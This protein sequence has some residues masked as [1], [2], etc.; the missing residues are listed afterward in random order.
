M[1]WV[2]DRVRS[3]ALAVWRTYR[4]GLFVVAVGI[5]LTVLTPAFLVQGNLF[6]V[7]TNA[8]VVA[9][10]GLG[11]TLVIASGNFD[12]SVGATASFAGAVSFST[13]GNL[14]VGPAIA[15]GLA[16]GAIVGFVNGLIVA[17]LRVPAFIATLGTMTIIRSM[18]LVYTDGH[19]LTLVGTTSYKALSAG[20]TPVML[21]LLVAAV[22][23]LVVANTRFGRH[24]LAVG[25]NQSASTRAG[26]RSNR[27]LWAVFAVVGA[28]A[29]LTGMIVSAQVLTANARLDTGLELSAIA[30][31][32]IGGTPLTGGRATMVGTLL[33]ALLIAEINNGLNL[34]NVSNYYQQLTTGILLLSAVGMS[35]AGR[36]FIKRAILAPISRTSE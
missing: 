2:V 15:V 23:A 17:E 11:M 4:V 7:S 12:L 14:G 34:L 29:A 10:V 22:M 8:A 18:T 31:V 16:A 20:L 21:A 25:S 35:T 1:T 28:T 24:V 9:I 5:V 6:N 19:D 32:V 30:V 33:G 26:V 13:V 36:R 27:I 3:A